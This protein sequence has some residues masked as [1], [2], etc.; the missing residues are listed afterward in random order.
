M[1]TI[2]LNINQAKKIVKSNKTFFCYN[3]NEENS[4]IDFRLTDDLKRYYNKTYKHF[5][6][7]EILT[8]K[9][10]KLTF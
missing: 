1:N 8:R 4:V 9:T 10:S 5:K 7:V 3:L 6:L 2:Y